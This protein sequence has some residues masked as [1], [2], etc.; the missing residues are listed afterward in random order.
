MT[1]LALMKTDTTTFLDAWGESLTR[2]RPT[3]TYDSEGKS[4]KSF[5][6]AALT[7]DHQPLSG[8]DIRA[9][10]GRTEK[11]DA[12]IFCAFDA[13]VLEGDQILR[14]TVYWDV[15]YVKDHEDHI[16]VFIRKLRNA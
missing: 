9:E 4:S 11:S 3:V 15:N 1:T 8:N 14:G 5:A 12:K 10:S 7:G 6:D 13:D 16:F 2:R